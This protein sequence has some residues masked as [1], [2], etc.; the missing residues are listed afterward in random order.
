LIVLAMV[1]GWETIPPFQSLICQSGTWKMSTFG[2]KGRATLAV[3]SSL[4][5]QQRRITMC[6]GQAFRN[7]ISQTVLSLNEQYW[8]SLFKMGI[9]RLHM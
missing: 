2:P 5:R 9:L 6:G 8:T 7:M 1:S 3:S 4:T